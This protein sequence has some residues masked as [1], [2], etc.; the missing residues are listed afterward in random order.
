L[1][2]NECEPLTAG[3]LR[4]VARHRPLDASDEH[5]EP[6]VAIQIDERRDVLTVDEDL[7][8]VRVF[9]RAGILEARR[10]PG[11]DV[12]IHPHVAERQ[13]RQ[14]VDVAVAI[15]I[16][17]AIPLPDLEVLVAVRSPFVL[18]GLRAAGIL[19]ELERR[20]VF[21]DEEIVI[22]VR[23]DID[24]LRPRDGEAREK[25]QWIRLPIFFLGEE[26]GKR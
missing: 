2:L 21:L 3:A 25:R 17:E 24:E 15:E 22:T 11:A 7:L 10:R 5:V 13:L 6:L 20:A 1:L 23:V 12:A 8:I 26:G 19:E 4:L 18:R 14:E 9:E 16:D